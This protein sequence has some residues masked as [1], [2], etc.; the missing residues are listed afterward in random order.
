MHIALARAVAGDN[1][2]LEARARPGRT[3]AGTTLP[4]PN[5]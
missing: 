5:P 1:A 3:S 4:V 2:A